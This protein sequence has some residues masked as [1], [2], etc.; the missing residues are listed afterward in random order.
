MRDGA[1]RHTPAARE[2]E[3]SASGRW[4]REKGKRYTTDMSW[5]WKQI[6]P[7]SQTRQ[8]R[9][10]FGEA[11]FG[12][13]PEL[14]REMGF[15]RVLVITG[16][17]SFRESRH[18]SNLEAR[19]AE[20]EIEMKDHRASGEPSPQSVDSI[21]E[22]LAGFEPDAVVAV[23]GGSVLDT[24]KAVAAAYLHEGSIK[25]YLE[26]VG[27]KTPSGRRLPFIAVPTTAGTGSEAT[28]NAVLSEVGAGGYKK[29]LRHDN[30]VADVAILDP[31][32]Q[33]SCPISVTGP[34]GL[35]AITQLLE[36]YVSVTANPI[37]HA[38][39]ESGLE[40]AGQAFRRVIND[41][42]DTVARAGM[43][44]AAYC[45]GVC[46][47]N[48][49]L[50]V[51]HGMASNAG[52]A[53]SI[54]HGVFCGTMLAGSVRQAIEHLGEGTGVRETPTTDEPADARHIA[55]ERYARAAELLADEPPDDLAALS[56]AELE[57]KA[58]ELI[59]TLDEFTELAQVPRLG[60]YGFDR[61]LIQT[62]AERS[63]VKNH[64]V[65]LTSNELFTLLESRL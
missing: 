48:A 7:F 52:S 4:T 39:A 13:L 35:D 33:T 8:P 17:S 51:V 47:A 38:M 36:A 42:N 18:W 43:A 23:G 60:E 15:G 30:F 28:K 57:D 26:G 20:R 16:G 63:G 37:T 46:L 31:A 10:E 1:A 44:Y 27:S 25:E 34:S 11:A 54:P 32:L 49:G 50:G 53:V 45:S 12:R 21:V 22:D 2:G 24:G 14:L 59:E 65:E 3:V 62:V 58:Q 55:L 41:G 19:L 64:P 40:A 5:N 6:T 9:V 56:D 29:S 61:N